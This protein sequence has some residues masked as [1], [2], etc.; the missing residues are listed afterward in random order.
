MVEMKGVDN[1]GNLVDMRSCRVLNP[2]VK[3]EVIK[4]GLLMM[5]LKGCIVL[6]HCDSPTSP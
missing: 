6:G 4:W 3:V 2:M 1:V 5:D